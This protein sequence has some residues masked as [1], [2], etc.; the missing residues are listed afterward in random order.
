M[1][2]E[3]PQ[4]TLFHFAN[5]K[6]EHW[7]AK[8]HEIDCLFP[9]PARIKSCPYDNSLTSE[10]AVKLR[11]CPVALHNMRLIFKKTLAYAKSDVTW[12]LHKEDKRNVLWDRVITTLNNLRLNDE[13]LQFRKLITE[14]VKDTPKSNTKQ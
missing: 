14:N 8:R 3:N 7:A 10:D 13:A 1:L 6:T 9:E 12:A 4:T 2:P 5:L 11:S